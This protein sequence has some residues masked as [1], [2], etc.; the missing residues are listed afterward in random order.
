ME[1]NI[2]SVSVLKEGLINNERSKYKPL[3]EESIYLIDIDVHD[4]EKEE[5][6]IEI[7]KHLRKVEISYKNEYGEEIQWKIY[8]ILDLFDNIYNLEVTEFPNE[9]YS[10]HLE[11]PQNSDYQDVLDKFYSDYVWED[12]TI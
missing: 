10:R 4:K 8:K 11:L 6:L 1:S 12:D 2:I 9:V 5:L 7:K 3:F